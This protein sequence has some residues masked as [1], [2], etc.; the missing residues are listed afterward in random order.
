MQECPV[1]TVSGNDC[2]KQG[3]KF[4]INLV[5]LKVAISRRKSAGKEGIPGNT[6]KHPITG[7]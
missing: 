7:M 1:G 3:R 6:H 2:S 5:T 4:I